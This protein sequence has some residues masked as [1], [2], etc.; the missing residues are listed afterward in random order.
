M[1]AGVIKAAHEQHLDIPGDISIAGF[2]DIPLASQLWPELTTIKQPL[3]AMA[4]RATENLIRI[5]RNQKLKELRVVIDAE[6]VIRQSTGP[7]PL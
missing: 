4:K 6:I 3:E 1:A 5:A 7:V 2:D